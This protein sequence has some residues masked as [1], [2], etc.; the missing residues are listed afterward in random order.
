MDL[1]VL[2]IYLP[3][4]SAAVRLPKTDAL[5]KTQV[6][7]EHLFRT[8]NS[9]TAVF[10]VSASSKTRFVESYQRIASE[11][12]IR[13][14][15]NLN[16]DVMQLVRDW[17]ESRYSPEWLM[18]V[19]NVD[20]RT[21]FLEQRDDMTTDKCLVEYIPQAAKGSLIYTTRSRD[22]GVD[23]ASGDEPIEVSSMD[24][25][26]R[27]SMLG[28]KVIRGSTRED[29]ETLLEEL[30]YLPLAISQATTFMVKRRRSIADYIG[31]LRNDSTRTR[32]LDHRTL[33]HGRHDR[34]SESVTRTWWIT[35]QWLKKE[36][37]RS[38]E[39]LTMMSLLDRQKI[40]LALVQDS[41]EDTLDFEEAIEVL[42]AFSL[43]HLYSYADVCDEEVIHA[44]AD[45]RYD[46]SNMSPDFCDMHRLV[47]ASTREWLDQPENDRIYVATKTLGLVSQVF[48]ST[49]YENLPLCRML[50]PHADTVLAY[51]FN[52]LKA[53][54]DQGGKIFTQN[55]QHRASLLLELSNYLIVQ[56]DAALSEDRASLSLDIRQWLFGPNESKQTLE[57]MQSLALSIQLLGRDAEALG[58]QR[59]ILEAR[60]RLMGPNDRSTLK[61]FGQI[62]SILWQQGEIAEAEMY[63]RR[64]LA[65]TRML[66]E[67]DPDDRDL[68]DSLIV[69][70]NHVATVQNDQ[71]E[72]EEAQT[73]LHEALELSHDIHG[74]AH[75]RT[76]EAMESLAIIKGQ[77]AK[78]DEA[79]VLV[80]EALAG[81]RK[82]FGET[83]YTTM[84]T[85][86]Q[87]QCLLSQE[88]KYAQAEEQVRLLLEDEVLI[89]GRAKLLTM[90]NFGTLLRKQKQYG[91]AVNIFKD[92]L[93]LLEEAAEIGPSVKI[94]GESPTMSATR[95]RRL[96]AWCLEVQGKTD[97]AEKYQSSS[98]YPSMTDGDAEELKIIREWSLGFHD[99]RQIKEVEAIA[100]E[101]L[102]IKVDYSGLDTDRKT[103][104]LFE[105]D[106]AL[107]RQDPQFDLQSLVRQVFAYRKR[108]LGWKH[109]KTRTALRVL[110]RLIEHQGKLEEAEVYYRQL[111]VWIENVWGKRDI[112]ACY[113]RCDLAE[114]LA[115]QL[116]YPEAE[117]L[118]RLNLEA[119][120]D[121]PEGMKPDQLA[122]TYYNLAC[123][124]FNQCH[125]AEAETYYHHA[126]NG[127]VELFGRS[128]ARSTETLDLLA[129]M[130]AEQGNFYKAREL[131]LLLAVSVALPQSTDEDSGKEDFDEEDPDRK[132]PN[133][134]WGVKWGN[135]KRQETTLVISQHH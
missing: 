43:I 24:V 59:K 86:N 87:Y 42:E 128:N 17:L 16:A 8:K 78:Y 102:E 23:L 124:L 117:K 58:M 5:S 120:L 46:L 125:I 81:R 41:G 63:H 69:A 64:D 135:A 122:L 112:E 110:A 3:S 76:W 83:H 75:P 4:P 48:P 121:D 40:L 84:S 109:D 45:R 38:A 67:Q 123:L 56:G 77:L 32:V 98:P 35:F 50:Y 6:V 53:P 71:G 30:A 132:V 114:V 7:L 31:L 74:R 22:I 119:Q 10:W 47:Q 127:Y 21:M 13:G 85:R 89:Y 68:T 52:R 18:V 118:L 111:A 61:S 20:D 94:R 90:H 129:R 91:R 107:L 72:W 96:I 66:H 2:G 95:T 54:D 55:M 14:Q 100:K 26:E 49:D 133:A 73:I 134:A 82:A 115:S 60:E 105:I 11:C 34:S 106:D 12:T 113:A 28:D 39:L 88:G 27:L 1:G 70:L 104:S 97:E 101:E 79:H 51:N 19:D 108:V 93:K 29:Q 80:A 116:K 131:H 36:H 65:G 37:P 103:T 62:G 15:D 9:S 33:H 99:E 130:A 126:Y 44:V 25:D 92:L 57:S